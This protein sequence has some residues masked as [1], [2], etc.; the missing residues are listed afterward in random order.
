MKKNIS[1]V[2]T[3]AGLICSIASIAFAQ[4][5]LGELDLVIGR[6]KTILQAAGFIVTFIFI[7]LGGYTLITAGGSAEK[8]ETGR[9]WIL[10]ALVGLA[11]ILIAE[12]VA[13]IACYIGTGNWT[14]PTP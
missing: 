3:I 7:M 5:G 4:Y 14:C 6:I 8:V 1:K 10:Y 13:R 11:V 9:K 12:A 2:L